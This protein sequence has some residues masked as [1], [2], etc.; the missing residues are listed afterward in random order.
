MRPSSARPGAPRLRNENFIPPGEIVPLGKVNVIIENFSND[1]DEEDTVTIQSIPEPE[2]QEPT[3]LMPM[4][5]DK[6]HLVEQILEQIQQDDVV[7]HTKHTVN[8]EWEQ[9]GK[10]E[11]SAHQFIYLF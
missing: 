9:D 11:F 4:P 8:I 10:T 2:F 5:T 7:E 1:L 3:V 6:G